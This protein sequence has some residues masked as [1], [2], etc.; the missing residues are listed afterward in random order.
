MSLTLEFWHP[1][2]IISVKFLKY[3]WQ[4]PVSMTHEVQTPGT[5]A[6]RVAG[7]AVWRFI[8]GSSW[9]LQD[10]AKNKQTKS[11]VKTD[12]SLRIQITCVGLQSGTIALRG[13]IFLHIL[14]K[15]VYGGEWRGNNQI[16]ESF[17]SQVRAFRLSPE[18]GWRRVAAPVETSQGGWPGTMGR[19]GRQPAPGWGWRSSQTWAART[20]SGRSLRRHGAVGSFQRECGGG[21]VSIGGLMDQPQRMED[22]AT[23]HRWTTL[24]ANGE[25]AAATCCQL[26]E[27]W[28]ADR[29]DRVRGPRK[30]SPKGG[31]ASPCDHRWLRW[32]V[33]RLHCWMASLN[34]HT[35]TSRPGVKM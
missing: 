11:T 4:S 19:R 14:Q 25:A 30:L 8:P 10:V 35:G 18:G 33:W 23:C 6:E 28:G 21:N 27:E 17:E 16:L 2:E 24:D 5:H 3:A 32:G 22:T 9:E 7:W 26:P 1:S 20:G 34:G 15:Q 31:A 29:R 12:S 13:L